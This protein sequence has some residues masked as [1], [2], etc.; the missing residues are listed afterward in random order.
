MS[1]KIRLLI[2]VCNLKIALNM[3]ATCKEYNAQHYGY[4][5]I[6]FMCLSSNNGFN[7]IGARDYIITQMIIIYPLL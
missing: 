6:L 3:K 5:N 7:N 2:K 1:C 4:K